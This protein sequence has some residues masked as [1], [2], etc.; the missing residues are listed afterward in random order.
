MSPYFVEHIII[1]SPSKETITAGLGNAYQYGF[2]LI[3]LIIVGII[4]WLRK[5]KQKNKPDS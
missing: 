5:R 1:N 4:V 3:A 2:V